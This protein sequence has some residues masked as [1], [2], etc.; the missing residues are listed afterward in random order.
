MENTIHSLLFNEN[1]K[2]SSASL[3]CM[4]LKARVAKDDCLAD[5][6][7]K[8]GKKFPDC[9]EYVKARAKQIAV[10]SCA[11]VSASDVLDWMVHFYLEDGSP[12]D[13]PKD[14]VPKELEAVD[15]SVASKIGDPDDKW[16]NAHD[17]E[18]IDN[19]A[20]L[21]EEK[22][23][24]GTYLTNRFTRIWVFLEEKGIHLTE[25]EV[26]DWVRSSV[27]NENTYANLQR[28]INSHMAGLD[29]PAEKIL[30]DACLVWCPYGTEKM[31]LKPDT[32]LD[33]DKKTKKAVREHDQISLF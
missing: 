32:K 11:A 13:L 17:I 22:T 16:A 33:A 25:D 19:R 24:A 6:V 18:E 20:K 29:E 5:H 26:S 31:Q 27:L 9:W 7:L 1:V 30:A 28:M 4:L 3:A 23:G 15:A 2:D 8:S 14:D 21:L 12:S 10:N